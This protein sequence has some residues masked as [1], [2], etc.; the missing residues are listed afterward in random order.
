FNQKDVHDLR[1]GSSLHGHSAVNSCPG[2][3]A[4]HATS[5]PTVLNLA[6][7]PSN[8]QFIFQPRPCLA[9]SASCASWVIYAKNAGDWP[10][11]S[12]MFVRNCSAPIATPCVLVGRMIETIGRLLS[13]NGHGSGMIS[14]LSKSSSSTSRSGNVTDTPV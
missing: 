3:D 8:Q 5:R 1:V 12:P 13:R 2:S 11:K 6:V 9:L 10:M 14:A 7:Q 4:N